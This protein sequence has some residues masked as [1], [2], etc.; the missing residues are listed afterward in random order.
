MFV[1][2]LGGCAPYPLAHYLKALAVLRLLAEKPDPGA[3]SWWRGERYLLATRLTK[4]EV[5]AFFEKEYAPSPIIAPWSKG[6]GFYYK[7]DP[8]ITPIERSA[9]P[10]FKEV[11]KAIAQARQLI[12][13]LVDADQAVRKIKAETKK[14]NLSKAAREAL[15]K[16]PGYKSRLTEAQRVFKQLKAELLPRLRIQWRGAL[17]EW[18]DAAVVLDEKGEAL[19]PAL[20][21]T[22]GNDGR[23]DFTNNFLQRI[24]EVYDLGSK[25]GELKPS[26][27]PRLVSA[28]WGRPSDRLQQ[29]RAVGQF[30]PGAAG[31]ANSAAGPTGDS[32]LNPFDFILMMEGALL[33]TA[34]LTRRIAAREEARAAAPFAVGSHAAGYSSAAGSDEDV[35]GEQWMPLWSQPLTLG[36]LRRLLSEGRAQIG[37]R[38]ARSPVDF[39][40][41]VAGLGC[42]RGIAAFQR[43]GYIERNGQSKLAVPLGRF[44]VPEKVSPHLRCLEDLSGWLERLHLHAKPAEAPARIVQVQKRLSEAVLSVT[45]RPDE[46]NQW[47]N[48]LSTLAEAEGFLREGSGLSVG[49]V[50]PLRPE[51]VT[52]ADDGSA[53]FRLAVACALQTWELQGKQPVD[54]V[55]RHW[56]PLDKGRFAA[57]SSSGERIR[58]GP[59]VVIMGKRGLDDAIALV[60]RRLVEAGQERA[61]RLPLVSAS[62]AAAYPSDLAR[63]LA[64]QVDLDRTMKLACALMA[65]D[66]SKWAARP[67]PPAPPAGDDGALPEEAWMVIRL[68]MAPWPLPNKGEVGVD[69][70]IFRRL[71]SGDAASAVRIA[72]RRLR[73][74]GIAAAP[75]FAFVSPQ[76]ARLWAAALAFPIDRKT[77]KR[78][79]LRIDPHILKEEAA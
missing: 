76:T 23:L 70:V 45:Q 50:P 18:L 15:R 55:R 16:D 28:L 36:E 47:Q 7:N 1:H 11:K 60:R 39:A 78:F 21:G 77:A 44:R 73:H 41:A 51:W 40:R 72:A 25:A 13:D 6:S 56:L 57:S 12:C 9:A 66:G 20:L 35:R 48:L 64:D 62:G 3:R 53:E 79:L 2:E 27:R 46:Q 5:E 58:R 54:G 34:H 4:E 43:Y 37:S 71:E 33:F 26:A 42:A 24:A 52:A 38:P 30:L 17:R 68:A 14:K 59:E 67:M 32:L 19:Y 49:P 61:H 74:V 63:L 75:R 8:G 31:G 69:P 65:V 22:G 29:G 10:R